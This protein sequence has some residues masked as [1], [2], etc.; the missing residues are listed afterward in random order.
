MNGTDTKSD[1]RPCGDDVAAYALGALDPVEAEAFRAHLETCSVCRDELAAFQH[2]VDVL[3][4]SATRHRTPRRLRRRV[5]DAV[6]SEP[7]L[8]FRSERR[9]RSMSLPLLGRLSTARPALALGAVVAVAALAVGAIELGTSGPVS[10]RVYA[11]QVTGPGSAHIVLT[12]S[13][14]QL[15]VHHLA[16]PP[17]GKIY[18]VWL[19]RPHRAPQP[20][21]AL[22]SVTA[23]GDGD[24]AV[25]GNLR[26]VHLV[27]VTPEPAGGS[28]VPT[29]APVIQ[30]RL[31]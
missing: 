8:D 6:G 19:G 15:I 27:M 12:G 21:S 5:L 1:P 3:P 22:F 26:G 11:A 2:V 25:P 9:R 10:S 20:T 7:K 30:A 17:A 24:V 23:G 16:P 29:G 31:T 14:A 28:R 18:E 13:H 4:L